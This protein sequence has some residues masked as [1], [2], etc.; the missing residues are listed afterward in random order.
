MPG[1]KLW[2]FE[3]YNRWITNAK[4]DQSTALRMTTG[5]CKQAES[6]NAV[7]RRNGETRDAY[8]GARDLCASMID[9]G[10]MHHNLGLD[11][12][13]MKRA[14]HLNLGRSMPVPQ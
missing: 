13:M 10:M 1:T 4:R 3:E 7:S 6:D 9:R 14:S 8:A 2:T 11:L 5:E 12:T